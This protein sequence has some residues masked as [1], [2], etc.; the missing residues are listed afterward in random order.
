MAIETYQCL[1]FLLEMSMVTTCRTC[2]FSKSI[3]PRHGIVIFMRCHRNCN[4]SATVGQSYSMFPF[5]MQR[6]TPV[7]VTLNLSSQPMD[8]FYPSVSSPHYQCMSSTEWRLIFFKLQ[9]W[10][11][12]WGLV[13]LVIFSERRKTQLVFQG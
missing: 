6:Y 2:W 4:Q 9:I 11:Q 5:S 7:A 12:P 1:R 3:K 8:L 13:V 10:M